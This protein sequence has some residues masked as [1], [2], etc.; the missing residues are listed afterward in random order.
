VHFGFGT[1]PTDPAVTASLKRIE[2]N[3]AATMA[4]L[5]ILNAQ[6]AQEAMDLSRLTKDVASNTTLAGS[7]KQSFANVAQILREDGANQAKVDALAETL[8]RDD[9]DLAT[10]I[11]QNT[12]APDP[13]SRP[14]PAT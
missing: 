10:L 1:C 14:N 5:G 12:P 4:K 8:E 13:T 6:G 2:A 11:P 7:L 9:A 3:Q